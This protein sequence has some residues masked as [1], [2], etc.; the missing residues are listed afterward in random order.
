MLFIRIGSLTYSSHYHCCDNDDYSYTNNT[1]YNVNFF[2]PSPGEKAR[3]QHVV[4]PKN[5]F[6]SVKRII[7]RT[8]KELSVIGEKLSTHKIDKK[9]KS[10]EGS[11]EI[12]INCPNLVRNIS[13]IEVPSMM[14]LWLT[15]I[16]L[17]I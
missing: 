9:H 13:P 15:S 7:G 12:S 16:R 17:L 14:L 2:L 6:S 3:R 5:T 11:E 4:N 8:I 1:D 10:A